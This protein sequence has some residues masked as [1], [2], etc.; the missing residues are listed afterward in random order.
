MSLLIIKN[1]RNSSSSFPLP[2]FVPQDF[3][4][5]LIF[6]LVEMTFFVFGKK[7]NNKSTIATA[8]IELSPTSIQKVSST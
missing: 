7:N 6:Q 5:H 4:L 2:K 1:I 8:Q 3:L